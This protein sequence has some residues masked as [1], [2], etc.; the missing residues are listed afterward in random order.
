MTVPCSCF[1]CIPAGLVDNR[2]TAQSSA[3]HKAPAALSTMGGCSS[4]PCTDADALHNDQQVPVPDTPTAVVGTPTFS[5]GADVI[6]R[7]PRSCTSSQLVAQLRHITDHADLTAAAKEVRDRARNSIIDRELLVHE[8]AVPALVRLLQMPVNSGDG[9]PHVAAAWALYYLQGRSK[10][11]PEGGPVAQ[12]AMAS[13]DVVTHA[14]AVLKG[15]WQD[16][17]AF[18]DA[19]QGSKL[20]RSA[21]SSATP[22][23]STS[24][25]SSK[26]EQEVDEEALKVTARVQEAAVAVLAGAQCSVSG[27]HI[28]TVLLAGRQWVGLALDAVQ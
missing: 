22:S 9:Q 10:G 15:A 21:S 13:A 16:S 6:R 24:P 12:S 26:S 2:P 7:S 11:Q 17:G 25:T 4:I 23:A 14:T 8:G 28:G 19:L 3:Q 18:A 5:C 27:G 1:H 20:V